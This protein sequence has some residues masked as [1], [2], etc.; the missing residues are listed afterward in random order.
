MQ[1]KHN[2]NR[3][4]KKLLV[5]YSRQETLDLHVPE[6][7]VII[8]C[9]GV[10]AWVALMLAMS[11]TKQFALHD[12]DVL[13]PHNLNRVP[14]PPYMAGQAKPDAL[15]RLLEWV[16]PD[17]E[18]YCFYER[19]NPEA[20]QDSGAVVFDCT[21]SFEFQKALAEAVPDRIR[22][23]YDG[24]T[25]VTVTSAPPPAWGN[26]DEEPYRIVPTWV[27]GAALAGIMG[28]AKACRYPDAERTV[29]LS[30]LLEGR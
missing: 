16:R 1:R 9:G 30:E 7:V 17:V 24:G 27:V 13:E 18:V 5:D 14:V 15:K 11:G 3:R 10:G 29:D 20:L 8:G 4:L 22:V 6:S 25:S 23:G 2:K 26:Q 12:F 19:V 21:D 28:A